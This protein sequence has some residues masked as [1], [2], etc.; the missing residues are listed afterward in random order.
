MSARLLVITGLPASGKSTLA[1]RLA[2]RFQ[3]PL[4]AKDSIKEPLLERL[5]A[6]DRAAS[7]RLSAASFAVLFAL[8]REQLASGLSVLLEGN[9]RSP[10]HDADLEALLRASAPSDPLRCAQLLCVAPEA[11]RRERLAAR[12]HDRLRHPGHRDAELLAAAAAQP[13]DASP[14]GAVPGDAAGW[15]RLPGTRFLH[16][17]VD[18]AGLPQLLATLDCWWSGS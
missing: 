13:L 5:G 10:E 3:A 17:G 4:L 18:G 15:L 14:G 11:L 2:V 9:F 12:S 7:R 8:A 1:H 6:L 16:E